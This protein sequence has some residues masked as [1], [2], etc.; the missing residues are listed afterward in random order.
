M[1]SVIGSICLLGLLSSCNFKPT[2]RGNEGS[3]EPKTEAGEEAIAS[4]PEVSFEGI[5]FRYDPHVFGDVKKEVVPESK[6]E[7]PTFKPDG[8]A[9][10]H[11]L[12][13]FDYGKEFNRWQFA[14]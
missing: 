2:V 1:K 7:D 3:L 12:F 8:V 6:L 11:V 5:T 4:D 13:E 14:V 10:E 9:P